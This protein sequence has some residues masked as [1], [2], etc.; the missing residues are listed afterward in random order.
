MTPDYYALLQVAPGADP[1]V[2]SAAYRRLALRYHPDRNAG[3][4]AAAMM[5]R[6]NEAYEVLSDPR[7]R[8]AYDEA[9]S[10]STPEPPLPPS[11]RNAVSLDHANPTPLRLEPEIAYF[12]T[13]GLFVVAGPLVLSWVVDGVGLGFLVPAVGTV[14]AALFVV[15]NLHAFPC[16]DAP[17]S[18]WEPV[19]VRVGAA[20]VL[21]GIV[22]LC[23]GWW[24]WGVGVGIAALA[25][26]AYEDQ[27]CGPWKATAWRAYLVATLAVLSGFLLGPRTAA[28]HLA[29]GHERIRVNDLD[30]AIREFTAAVQYAPKDPSTHFLRGIACEAAGN[31][32]SALADYTEVVRLNPRHVD[33]LIRR[34]ELLSRTGDHARAVD[35]LNRATALG[36]T[37]VQDEQVLAA[38][39]R[40]HDALGRHG[41]AHADRTQLA[42][43]NPTSPALLPIVRTRFR[44][45]LVGGGQV[46]VLTNPGPHGIGPIGVRVNR[47]AEKVV[48]PQLLAP[49][50]SVEAGWLELGAGLS[51]GDRVAV[52]VRGI[53][54]FTVVVP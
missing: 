9:R 31:D 7:K 19:G 22:G 2:I 35:D 43:R 50:Q 32:S 44:Q 29:C 11:E 24:M 52:T 47:G 41:D 10:T 37:A 14:S 49:S 8:A 36:L 40:S 23:V 4:D 46:L 21:A 6:I 34:G 28:Y 25:W 16:L 13:L 3:T 5:V 12:G 33:A 20:A 54:A 38:R 51:T 26:L 42:K 17:R 15:L 48:T 18:V 39:V 45:S 1:E 27:K 53:V 30:G